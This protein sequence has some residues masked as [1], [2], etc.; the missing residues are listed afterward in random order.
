MGSALKKD[1]ILTMRVS[2]QNKELLNLAASYKGQDLTSYV[3]GLAL[4][5]A[6]QDIKLRN[7][8]EKI[9]L[10]D[11]DFAAIKS[12][13]EKPTKPNKTL[14]AAARRFKDKGL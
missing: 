7:E 11:E 1:E 2:S 13:I 12:E 6:F 9:V 5:Q 3:L 10:T 14:V 8:V 4:E